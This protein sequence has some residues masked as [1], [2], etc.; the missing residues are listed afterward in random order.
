MAYSPGRA[1]VSPTRYSIL[2]GWLKTLSCHSLHSSKAN[3]SRRTS[4]LLHC[5]EYNEHPM[6]TPLASPPGQLLG[7]SC[8]WCILEVLVRRFDAPADREK[9][10]RRSS[11]HGG[12]PFLWDIK[13]T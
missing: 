9:R 8:L 6:R 1:H 4:G 2:K 13:A 11:P 3:Q 12:V 7:T 10:N 5:R